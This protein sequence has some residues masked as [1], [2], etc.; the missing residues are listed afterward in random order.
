MDRDQQAFPTSGRAGR[1][2]LQALMLLLALPVV[3]ILTLA[4]I[5]FGG[6]VYI[7]LCRRRRQRHSSLNSSRPNFKIMTELL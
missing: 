5:A 1:W 6:L 4:L 7:Q 2:W 3:G